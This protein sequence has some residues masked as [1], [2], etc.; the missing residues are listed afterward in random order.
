MIM[1][2]QLQPRDGD[3]VGG[4]S[5]TLPPSVDTPAP[6]DTPATLDD[7]ALPPSRDVS[8][9][10]VLFGIKSLHASMIDVESKACQS[11]WTIGDAGKRTTPD[12]DDGAAS[13]PSAMAT[14]VYLNNVAR[15][16][17]L[18]RR[19]DPQ[20]WAFAWRVDEHHVAVAEACY[21]WP[22]NERTKADTAAVR[23]LCAAGIEAGKFAR[24]AAVDGP[25]P[26]PAPHAEAALAAPL[27]EVRK[28]PAKLTYRLAQ[29]LRW[30]L[31]AVLGLAGAVSLLAGLQLASSREGE[32][33]RLR[34][35]ADGAMTQQLAR[36]LATGDYGEVQADLDTFEG[37]N[38]FRGAMV[39]DA[40]RRA[41]A[42]AGAVPASRIGQALGAAAAADARIVP[43]KAAGADT[44]GLLL[45]WGPETLSPG[46][47]N[48]ERALFVA[49][50][51]LTMTALAGA[52]LMWR[53]RQR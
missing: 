45:I 19:I 31:L 21:R 35:L 26:V 32:A 5:A 10:L 17:T 28:P 13:L 1:I 4:F 7:E 24:A 47:S 2:A 44:D 22:N 16:Q 15:E 6:V 36:V 38:Y 34:S 20:R 8:Q 9:M 42:R 51:L 41:V 25:L 27:P 40:R 23:Q 12:P 14:I 3:A 50:L 53:Q 43:L 11:S 46:V 49:C 33:Q 52:A 48:I 39:V 30:L 18:T 29:R 37:L